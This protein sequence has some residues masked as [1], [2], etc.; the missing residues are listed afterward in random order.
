MRIHRKKEMKE[1]VTNEGHEKYDEE[2]QIK[3]KDGRRKSV[4]GSWVV[5]GGLREKLGFIQERR[6]Y[7]KHGIC[8]WRR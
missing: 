5:G 4:M 2:Y 8:G 3:R 7:A 1:A 6:K